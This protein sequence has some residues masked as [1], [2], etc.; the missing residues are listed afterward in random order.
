MMARL[1]R[2]FAR[3]AGTRFKVRSAG[4][5]SD[6]LDGADFALSSIGGSGAEITRTVHTSTF[7][8]ADMRIPTRYGIHQLIGD[9]GGPGGLMMGL[10]SVTAHLRILREMEKR[11]PRVIMFNH[12]NPMA[13]LMRAMHKYTSIN[14]IGVC[15]GVQGGTRRTAE[16]M[17]LEPEY[18]QAMWIGTNHYYWF[19]RFLYKGQD[20]L[21]KLKQYIATHEAPKGRGLSYRLSNIYGHVLVYAMDDHAIEFYPFLSHVPGGQKSLPYDLINSALKHDFDESAPPVRHVA[22]PEVRRAFF[23]E[24]QEILNRRKMPPRSARRAG[25]H[26]FSEEIGATLAAIA[27][28]KRRIFIANIA[29][30]GAIPNLPATAE[31]EVE[32]VTDWCGPPVLKGMLEKR[33]AWQ[34][35]VADAA[36]TGDRNLALQAMLLD[37]MAIWPE[38]AEAMLDELLEA[39]RPLLGQFFRKRRA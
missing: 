8:E 39:S 1:G 11:C 2:K 33:F 6:A 13:V 37:E 16:M 32:S 28:G 22:S 7:H 35:L 31:V 25:A 3:Q 14:A 12:S 26:A 17:G 38:Q 30:N 4:R 21:P 20:Y 27:T 18:V 5:L 15:H 23:K 19:T 29:N 34:E 36:V 24:Y 10:R 9:T